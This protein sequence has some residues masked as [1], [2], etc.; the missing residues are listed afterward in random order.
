MSLNPGVLELP[1]SVWKFSQFL[2][3]VREMLF[4]IVRVKLDFLFI[5]LQLLTVNFH[6]L[7]NPPSPPDDVSSSA[8]EKLG[9]HGFESS[10]VVLLSFEPPALYNLKWVIVLILP[11]VSLIAYL[12][13]SEPCIVLSS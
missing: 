11:P 9:S 3:F 6:F 10:P 5:D 7:N 1:S 8:S 2:L 4:K 13:P 12:V